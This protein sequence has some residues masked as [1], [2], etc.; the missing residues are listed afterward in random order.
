LWNFSIN[1]ALVVKTVN[2]T[3]HSKLFPMIHSHSSV[4]RTSA[5]DQMRAFMC[6]SCSGLQ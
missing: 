3:F 6:V 2:L 1:L 5:D 4:I